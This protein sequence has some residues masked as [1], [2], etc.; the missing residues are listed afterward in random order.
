[1]GTSGLPVVSCSIWNSEAGS[2]SLIFP[3]VPHGANRQLLGFLRSRDA[4]GW[5]GQALLGLRRRW[6]AG[7]DP[8]HRWVRGKTLSSSGSPFHPRV[9]ELQTRPVDQRR[10]APG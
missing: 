2:T 8:G 7:R 4:A 6:V 9:P 1:V 10:P 5:G 3:I